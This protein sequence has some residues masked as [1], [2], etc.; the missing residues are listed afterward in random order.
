MRLSI[1]TAA[2]RKYYIWSII[3]IAGY[4]YSFYWDIPDGS[5]DQT[6]A[7]KMPDVGFQS[8]VMSGTGLMLAFV[9]CIKMCLT[10]GIIPNIYHSTICVPR[11]NDE[12]F[13]FT[14]TPG[15]YFSILAGLSSFVLLAAENAVLG[16]SE[17]DSIVALQAQNYAGA[18][19]L[20][21][22]YFTGP[23]RRHEVIGNVF[24]IIWVHVYLIQS[25]PNFEYF[26][27]ISGVILILVSI[28]TVFCC[29]KATQTLDP[30]SVGIIM[31]VSQ[32][33]MGLIISVWY[34]IHKLEIISYTN[35]LK[36]VAYSIA[37]YSLANCYELETSLLFLF[38]AVLTILKHSL[39]TISIITSIGIFIGLLIILFGDLTFRGCSSRSISNSKSPLHS[40]LL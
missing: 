5:L 19:L 31:L 10:V 16:W 34:L 3:G 26:T 4:C 29:R 8:F 11:F 23:Q 15:F 14:P 24:I 1:K 27:M 18:V 6:L 9:S 35:I 21:V 13:L 22:F 28:T 32:G 2:E 39:T 36:G 38:P 20:A 33:T 37:N 30:H 7:R 12:K 40:P 25:R 17:I